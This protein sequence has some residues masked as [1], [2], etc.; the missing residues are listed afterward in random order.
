MTVELLSQIKGLD[1]VCEYLIKS[2]LVLGFLLLLAFLSRKKSASLRHFLL[3]FSLISLLLIPFLSSIT[4]GWE[5]RLLPS[6]QTGKNSSYISNEWAKSKENPIQ[7]KH[8]DLNI[9]K[10]NT[11]KPDVVKTDSANR[12][13]LLS[14]LAAK[15]NFLGLILITLWSVGL[16]FLL[17]R[18][19][20]GLYGAYRLTRQGEKI[21]GSPWQQLLQ[22]FLKAIPLKRKVSLFT[23]KQAMVPLTWGVIKPVIIIPDESRKWTKGQCS[24]AL[25]HELSHIKRGDFLVKIIARI[26]CAIFWFNPLSWLTFKIMKKEQE[27]ACD[28]LVLKAG[29]RPSTY[30]ANLLLIKRSG[31]AHWNLPTTVLGAVGKSQLNER[32]IAILKKQF[33]SKEIKMKTKI[34]LSFTVILVITVIGLA[35]PSHTA[36]YS[37]KS[38]SCKDILPSET[39]QTFQDNNVQE[40]QE[41]KES[42]KS[43]KKKSTDTKDK[44]KEIKWITKEGKSG[45]VEVHIIKGGKPY[46]INSIAG[47]SFSIIRKDGSKNTFILRADGKDLRLRKYKEGIW[48][49]KGDE[50]HLHKDDEVKVIRLN[51]GNVISIEID[52][53][54]DGCKSVVIKSPHI[55]ISKDKK[56]SKSFTIHVKGDKGE[57]KTVYI[58]HHV[59]VHPF[60]HLELKHEKLKEKIKKIKEK[61]KK[62]KE[63]EDLDAKADLKEEILKELEESLEELSEELEK[64]SEKLKDVSI[65]IH[66]EPE[67]K[68]DEFIK[69]SIKIKKHLSF[70]DVK[71]EEEIIVVVDKDN[72]IQI[73]LKTILDKENKKKY[74]ETLKKLK[75]SLPEGCEVES[76]INKDTNTITIKI[77]GIGKDKEQKKDL[78]SLIKEI[79]EEF[80]KVK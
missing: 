22:R 72:G 18:I 34:M 66:A 29:V 3:S 37:E 41:K 75:E 39:N 47:K 6:W 55:F 67:I 9:H 31:Q 35:R 10:K 42:E 53:D 61:L 38:F 52:K 23:H 79:V 45:C 33:N 4:I 58:A 5:T 21:S 70:V 24:S 1:L 40:K 32:L 48:T 51:K 14:K 36:A 7:G 26:S 11:Q 69:D 25:F 15:K 44:K 16:I 46:K 54:K 63:Q 77:S 59:E 78:K 76:E 71:D 49:I 73:I 64:K 50:L 57:K 56:G 62:I 74:E 20:L 60:I 65:S 12:G 68:I 27:K 43:K 19:F 17:T 13:S 8:K 80:K 30:A 28:E 2:S